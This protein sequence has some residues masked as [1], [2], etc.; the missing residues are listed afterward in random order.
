MADEETGK[1][2]K[3]EHIKKDNGNW[4]SR[5]AQMAAVAFVA[6]F[7]V[8]SLAFLVLNKMSSLEWISFNQFLIPIVLSIY[9]LANVGEKKIM[10]DDR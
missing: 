6:P 9:G 7:I 8:S 3:N 4:K 5:K 10:K 2:P 1:K